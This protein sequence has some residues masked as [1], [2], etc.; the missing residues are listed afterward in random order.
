[1]ER[2]TFIINEYKK[3][4]DFVKSPFRYAGGK[5]YALKYIMPFIDAIP[6]DEYREPFVGG[7]SIFFAKKKV[8]YNWIND[9]EKE[10]IK[11][12]H[13][14][15]DMGMAEVIARMLRAE[16][17]SRDRFEEVRDWQP[18][19]IVDE[20]YKTYYLNR[21]AYCGIINKPA[22]G[23]QEKKS[24]PPQN[25]GKFIIDVQPK[26]QDITITCSDFSEVL[27]APPKGKNMLVYLDPPY[28]RADQ[29]RAYIKS[30]N[31]KDHIRLAEMLR[32][33]DFYFCLS[34]DDVS[35]VRDLYSWAYIHECS[36]L[37]NTANRKGEARSMGAELIITNYK[38]K[39][40]L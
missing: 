5:F 32:H 40:N 15:S 10:L 34:Y 13:A 36:W 25:W 4:Q 29:Q 11:V 39:Q 1:M 33:S 2:R 26:L 31:E 9:L 14:F 20:V 22:W 37:Y 18:Q 27:K 23:Y 24:S 30:F 28:F 17:A 19:S 38:V 8:C 21:T 35:E 12:Y 7:G 3:S 16:T 6:H